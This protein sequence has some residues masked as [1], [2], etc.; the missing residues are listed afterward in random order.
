[1][2]PLLPPQAWSNS[3][4]ALAKL[5]VLVD[6][7]WVNSFLEEMFLKMS[8]CNA[9]EFANMLWALARLNYR[10]DQFWLSRSGK[11]GQGPLSTT[12]PALYLCC[13]C[14]VSGCV[15]Y[16]EWPAPSMCLLL[17]QV[18]ASHP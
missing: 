16:G 1:M 8:L 6:V 7:R 2:P 17:P 18:C 15:K 10:P 9:Q 5:G 4:W 12:V 3:A 11:A 14:P 13:A